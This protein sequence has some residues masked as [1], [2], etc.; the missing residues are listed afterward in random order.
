M[1]TTMLVLVFWLAVVAAQAQKQPLV[2]EQRAANQTAWMKKQLNLTAD[3]IPK[4]EEINLRYAKEIQAIRTQ[5]GQG[6]QKKTAIA[7]LNTKKD[8]ELKNVF[9]AEQLQL[10]VQKKAQAVERQ[11]NKAKEKGKGKGKGKG[12]EKTEPTD[13]DIIDE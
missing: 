2:P 5:T 10:Y 6:G 13:L 11:K 1:R 12:K 8:A 9:T 7:D 3:Q 4:V